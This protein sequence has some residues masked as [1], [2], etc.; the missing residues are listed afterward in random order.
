LTTALLSSW[1]SGLL[2]VLTASDDGHDHVP[3]DVILT[4]TGA[5]GRVLFTQDKD[6]LRMAR[7]LQSEGVAF[8]GVIYARMNYV[9]IGRCVEDLELIAKVM[10]PEEFAGQVRYLPM[11]F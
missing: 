7:R 5:L 9:S 10:E 8:G 3:D 1:L 2:D 6:F 11:N 4:R